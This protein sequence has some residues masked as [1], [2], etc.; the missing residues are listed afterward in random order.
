[1]NHCNLRG[2][3][4]REV[5]DIQP[6]EGGPEREVDCRFFGGN[7]KVF[8]TASKMVKWCQ[9]L[10]QGADQGSSCFSP[11]GDTC[12]VAQQEDCIPFGAVSCKKKNSLVSFLFFSII[13]VTKNTDY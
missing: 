10:T 3:P 1:M 11:S 2:G 12:E 13:I 4:K 7:A 6:N 9:C 8:Q 5:K